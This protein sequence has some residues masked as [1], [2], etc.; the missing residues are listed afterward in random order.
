MGPINSRLSGS[1]FSCGSGDQKIG[2]C[3]GLGPKSAT[4]PGRR[5]GGDRVVTHELAVEGLD[6]AHLTGRVHRRR[7]RKHAE[8]GAGH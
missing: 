3:A 4:A 6:S 2:D 8:D 7:D 5:K 1:I